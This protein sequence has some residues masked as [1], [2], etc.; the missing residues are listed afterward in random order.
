[1]LWSAINAIELHSSVTPEIRPGTYRLVSELFTLG[2]ERMF[3]SGGPED[4]ISYVTRYRDRSVKVE[5][6]AVVFADGEFVGPDRGNSYP[7]VQGRFAARR[8]VYGMVMR[9]FEA[10]LFPAQTLDKLARM[11]KESGDQIPYDRWAKR[12]ADEL[13]RVAKVRGPAEALEMAREGA[14]Y[15]VLY[16]RGA[17]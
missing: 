8:D 7:Y 10:G 1:M 11:S 16:R 15:P 6:D 2:P 17:R 12:Y 4:A 9:D 13:T 14:N 3:R 5:L